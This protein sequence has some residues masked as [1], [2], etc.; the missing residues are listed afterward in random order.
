MTGADLSSVPAGDTIFGWIA[1][2]FERGIRRPGYPA[3]QWAEQWCAERFRELGLEGVRLEPVEVPRWEPVDWSLEVTGPGGATTRVPCFPLPHAAPADGLELDLAAWDGADPGAVA[4]RAALYDVTLLRLPAR[5]F[6]A[7]GSAPA[8]LAGRAVDP[9]GTLARDHVLPFGIEIQAV[10]EPAIAAGAGAFVGMLLGYPGDSCE[11]YVP[12]DG[13]ERPIPGVWVSA[14]AGARLH[15]ML[16]EGPVRARL[17]VESERRPVTTHNVVG[18]LPGADDEVV[19]IGSHHD[20]PWASAVE[21]A[22]GIALVLA[23]AATWAAVPPPLR[24]HRLVFVLHGGHMVGGA[25]LR[26]HI[27]AHRAELA[28]VV[29]ELHL[30]HAALEVGDD[31]RPGLPVPRWW[32]TSRNPAL[33]SAVAEA[34]VAERLHRSMILAPDALGEHPPTDGGFYHLEGVPLV[35]FLAA[36]HYLFDAMDTLDKI[37]RDHLVPLSRAAARIVASTHGVSAAAMRDGI[38][39]LP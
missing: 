39:R 35:N 17:T 37:D 10:M 33:E 1:T 2:V 34:L 24:P 8:D 27:E 23:Q 29:L 16:G 38:V 36:P 32:F 14:S 31:G 11:Y 5:T 25:G 4:G 22:S 7:G 13:A 28:S 6:L 18:E 20:G 12:Y 3:D 9:E 26:A 30:E 21:D 15:G 19:M